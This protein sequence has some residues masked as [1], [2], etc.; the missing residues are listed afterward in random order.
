MTPSILLVLLIV[1]GASALLI[2]EALRADLV[3]LFVLVLL[4]V[5]GLVNPQEA[6]AGFSRPAL[7]TVLAIFI[8]TAGL[9]RT[10]VTHAIGARLLKIAGHK[11]GRLIPVVM[12]AGGG[13]SLFMNTIAAAAVLLPAVMGISRQTNVKP[14]KLLIPLSF[15]VLLGGMATL[16]TTSNILVSTALR[17]RGLQPF[18]LLDFAP[19]GLPMLI[20]GIAYMTL[21]GRRWLPDRWPAGQV[22]RLQRLQ[23][24]LTDLYGLKDGMCAVY[25]KPGSLM[26]GRSL[27]EGQWGERLGLNVVGVSRGGRITLAPASEQRIVEGDIVLAGGQ[28]DDADLSAHGL[29]LTADPA[30]NGELEGQQVSLVEVLIAP[31]ST[32]PG[33]TLREINFREKFGL[34]VLAIWREG[35]AIRDALAEI[36]LQFGD[37]LLVQGPRGKLRVL[38]AEPDFLVLAEPEEPVDTSR[39]RR[40]GLIL[41]GALALA[42]F[43]VLPIAEATI[44]GAVVMILAGCLKMDEAYRAIEWRAIF[45]IAGMLPLGIALDKSGAA[46]LLGGRLVEA[47]GRFGPLA[48]AMGLF[49]LTTLLVQAMGN[50]TTAV[51]LAPIAIAAAQHLGSDP[52]GFAMAVA[53]GTSMGFLTPV[54]HPVNILV[55]GPGGYT[56]RDFA[57]VGW[58][59]T[60]LLFVVVLICLPLFWRIG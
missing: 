17:D 54:S 49:A 19:V 29:V 58:P 25:V 40:A 11:T 50:V 18:G 46:G 52:R 6:F 7:I 4:A 44:L 2:T 1:V 3:A 20:A 45:L 33:Q 35:R 5:S 59:L 32:L 56:F 34:T 21:V 22:E 51:V 57:K 27:A 14:S 38:R 8:L 10:G 28:V 42:A 15:A 30:W 47:V 23:A 55:M 41:V 12:A 60:V 39:S 37:A 16:L 26:A 53:L 13:L 24:E 43:G 36:P 9:E 48:L 31:R